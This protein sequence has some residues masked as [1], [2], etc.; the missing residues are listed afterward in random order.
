[1][2]FRNTV[3]ASRGVILKSVQ[4]APAASEL[5]NPVQGTA[6]ELTT[7]GP[8]NRETPR[9]LSPWAT[10]MSTLSICEHSFPFSISIDQALKQQ[11]AHE[12]SGQ[13]CTGDKDGYQVVQCR[14]EVDQGLKNGSVTVEAVFQNKNRF[15][16]LEVTWTKIPVGG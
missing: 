15:W 4:R 6:P 8:G 7:G 10:M 14:V 16:P 2:L 5:R 1:M 13:G 9:L 3:E 11:R 12:A